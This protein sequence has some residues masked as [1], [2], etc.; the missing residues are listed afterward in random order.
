MLRHS[1]SW[2][3]CELQSW[4]ICSFLMPRLYPA[5]SGLRWGAQALGTRRAPPGTRAQP[6]QENPALKALSVMEEGGYDRAI[7]SSSTES[8]CHFPLKRKYLK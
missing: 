6:G 2:T 4:G 5:L 3:C 7:I 8:Q 1:D